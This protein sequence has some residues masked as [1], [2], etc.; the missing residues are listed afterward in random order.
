GTGAGTYAT[1]VPTAASPA[2]PNPAVAG[3]YVF[4]SSAS[5]PVRPPYGIYK[6]SS[7]S[8]TD[9]NTVQLVAPAFA[10]VDT[11]QVSRDGTKAIYIASRTVTDD[12]TLYVIDTSGSGTPTRIDTNV[13]TAAISADGTKVV[14]S[15]FPTGGNFTDLYVRFLSET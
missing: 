7:T 4:A 13:I 1:G 6:G 3:Q 2:S 14:Y 5:A 9:A 8:A 11:V 12:A 10:F 15:K